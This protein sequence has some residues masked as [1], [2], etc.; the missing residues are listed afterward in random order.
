VVMI[1]IVGAVV[2]I[3]LGLLW[4]EFKLI[5]FDPEFAGANGF[6]ITALQTL[7]STLIVIAI[8]L[9]LQLAGVILMVGMLIAPGIAARQWTHRLGQMVIL[10]AVFGAFAG[11]IGAIIS[12]IDTDVPTGP[13]IIVVAF[14]VVVVSLAFA[15]GRGLLW[16]LLRARR[17]SRR[18]AAQNVLRDIYLYGLSHDNHDIS[19]PEGF[20]IGLRGGIIHTGLSALEQNGHI[21]RAGDGW[22][23]TDAGLQ[24]A[25]DNAYNQQLWDLYRVFGDELKLPFV[26]EDRQKDIRALLPETAIERLESLREGAA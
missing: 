4:K 21:I 9:G 2:F 6:H 14:S 11:G 10:S 22:R 18:F 20:L 23:L 1:S 25:E 3:T 8:V 24:T 12:A 26:S 17:D 15:P 5:T 7:L 19:V 13:T 16:A